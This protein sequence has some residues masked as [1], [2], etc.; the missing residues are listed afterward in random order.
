M[1]QLFYQYQQAIDEI[2]QG[3]RTEGRARL[4]ELN[5]RNPENA[6]IALSLGHLEAQER[7]FDQALTLFES[8]LAHQDFAAQG[9]AL[10]V[11][12]LIRAGRGRDATARSLVLRRVLDSDPQLALA[13]AAAFSSIYDFTQAEEVLAEQYRK[14]P[15][16]EIAAARSSALVDLGRGAEAIA[17]LN[18]ALREFPGDIACL[19]ALANA[20]NFVSDSREEG[21]RRHC[22]LGRMAEYALPVTDPLSF[23]NRPDPDRPLRIALLSHDFRAHSVAYFVEAILRHHD[24]SAFH[25]TAFSTS[26]TEDAVSDRLRSLADDWKSERSGSPR[27]LGREVLAVSPDVVIELGGLTGGSPLPA[28]MPQVAPVQIS[29]IGYPNTT[30]FR[31]VQFRFVDSLTDPPGASDTFST[32]KL[33]R[34]DP[35]FLC[36]TP[37]ARRPALRV[38]GKEPVFASFNRVAK[39]SEACVRTWSEI[40]RRSA[41]ARLILKSP[42]L[43]SSA[44]RG[45]L[46]RR[47]AS[48]GAPPERIELIG[49]QQREEDHLAMYERIDIALDSFPYNGTTT[50]CE[51]L[52]QGVPVVGLE[53]STHAGRVGASLL[54]AA[55]FPELV[56][57]SPDEYVA[58]AAALAPRVD[59]LRAARTDRSQRFLSSTLCDG[60]AYT[61]RWQDAVRLLWRTWCEQKRNQSSPS[62]L[63]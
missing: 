34:L 55:G 16:A 31:A 50:T 2:R 33:I 61:A 11:Q 59:E 19:A 63:R 28:L 45:L 9:A 54:H 43:D 37:R 6:Q 40:L 48:A 53:G 38:D 46:M 35:C 57:R 62:A 3:K 15:H 17:V 23:R 60:A 52:M 14:K 7:N 51:A 56:A 29:A 36:F 58:N 18:E 13:T 12:T 25:L 42:A 47:F 1:S 4:R 41:G 26:F 39:Y 27:L 32:E 5:R 24:R 30:G 20:T 49:L 44:A 21:F 22:A 10:I 8:L